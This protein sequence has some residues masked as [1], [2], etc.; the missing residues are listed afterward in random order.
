[1]FKRDTAA[2][3]DSVDKVNTPR[4]NDM[5]TTAT[6]RLGSEYSASTKRMMM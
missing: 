2:T 6:S 1:M 3:L 4:R 5:M